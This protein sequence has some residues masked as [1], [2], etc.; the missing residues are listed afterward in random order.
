MMSID[1][2]LPNITASTE[3]GQMDQMRSYLYQLVQQ[4]NWALNAVNN[5]ENG[6]SSEISVKGSNSVGDIEKAYSNFSEIKS[7]IIKSADIV[8]AYYDVI[9][10][11][12]EGVYVSEADF[13]VFSEQTSNDIEANSKNITQNYNDIQSISSD[14]ETI[15]NSNIG[16]DS[17]IKTGLLEYDPNGI[18]IYGVE[19]GQKTNKDGVEIFNKYARFTGGGIYFYLPGAS[20]AVAWMSG[21]KLYIT[22]A[23]VTGSLKL[24][25]YF[26]DLSNGI[27]FKWVGG[28]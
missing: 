13:G 15:K 14:I 27:A 5:A 22:N 3:T 26:C 7:L 4:L 23:E 19:V 21:T 16:T 1:I 17:W 11:R 25:K 10:K 2:R 24:G 18:P 28:Q 6:D 12:L 20:D 8:N 9:S